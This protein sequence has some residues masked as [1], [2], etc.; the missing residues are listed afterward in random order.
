MRSQAESG[1]SREVCRV[2]PKFE[3]PKFEK[4]RLYSRH[5][6]CCMLLYF[7]TN[8]T[9]EITNWTSTKVPV[10]LAGERIYV[11]ESSKSC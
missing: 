3:V 5:R 4:L 9:F 11:D 10:I 6:I 1:L 2:V 7:Q 8:T